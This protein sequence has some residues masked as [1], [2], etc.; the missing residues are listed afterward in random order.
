MEKRDI[1]TIERYLETVLQ[2]RC[3]ILVMILYLALVRANVYHIGVVD[4]YRR[5]TCFASYGYLFIPILVFY[6]SHLKALC[7]QSSDLYGKDI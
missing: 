3:S 7:S 2:M 6:D 1:T 5:V 4:L